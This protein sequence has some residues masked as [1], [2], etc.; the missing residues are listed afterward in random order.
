MAVL[1]ILAAANASISTI[2]TSLEAGPKLENAAHK[3]SCPMRSKI[4]H[5]D[6]TPPADPLYGGSTCSKNRLQFASQTKES[7]FPP[8]DPHDP[9][10][11]EKRWD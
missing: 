8:D 1:E 10:W 6:A 2:K 11:Y 5:A 3:K 7:Y 4:T 9:M